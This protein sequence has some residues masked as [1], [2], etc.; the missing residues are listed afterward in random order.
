MKKTATDNNNLW[1]AYY[2]T[3]TRTQNLGLE[4]QRDKV[5]RSAQEQGA[6]IIAEVQEQESG[7]ECS[8]PQLNKV[9]ALA[10]KHNAT[11]VVAKHDRLSRDLGFATDLIFKS[12]LKFYCL[13]MPPMAMQNY[14]VFGAM[15]GLAS[16][17]ARLIS[18]RTKLALQALKQQGVKLGNPKGAEAITEDMVKSATEARI[19][20]ANENSN[21]VASASEIRA[22]VGNGKKTLQEIADHL[23]NNGYLTSRGNFHTRKSVQLL[24]N[25][26]GIAI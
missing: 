14:V 19:R 24:C 21:N 9:L 4:A 23:N 13:N 17:E 2:R 22:F 12:G 6:T 8:R 18:E 3:S 25:R 10:R 15:F 20:K 5:M 16:E 1:I 7:K 26:F 11:I